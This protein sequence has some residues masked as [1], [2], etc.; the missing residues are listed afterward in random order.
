VTWTLSCT[1]ALDSPMVK[2]HGQFITASVIGGGGG[3][4]RLKLPVGGGKVS[5]VTGRFCGCGALPTSAQHQCCE[6]L[7]QSRTERNVKD[8]KVEERYTVSHWEVSQAI[9]RTLYSTLYTTPLNSGFSTVREQSTC[10]SSA[11]WP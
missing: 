3:L 2:L 11:P 7:E 6:G 5:S 1:V 4:H 8:T 10:P 9:R